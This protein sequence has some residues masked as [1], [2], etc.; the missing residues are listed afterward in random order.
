ARA[1]RR[2]VPGRARA[3][4]R[5]P[6]GRAWSRGTRPGAQRPRPGRP[7]VSAGTLVTLPIY[8]EGA[9]LGWLLE[10]LRDARPAGVDVL[11]VDDASTDRTAERIRESGF[12]VL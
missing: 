8:N 1:V 7:R 11:F 5:V 4:R 12:E 2:V 9:R 3:G 6:G 10:R